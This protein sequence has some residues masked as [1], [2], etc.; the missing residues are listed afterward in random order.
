MPRQTRLPDN[1][2]EQLA[3]E[4]ERDK[5]AAQSPHLAQYTR[6]PLDL[7]MT[8]SIR[9][10]VRHLSY[11][12]ALAAKNDVSIQHLMREGMELLLDKHID[13]HKT[14]PKKKRKRAAKKTG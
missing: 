4:P 9:L 8:Y 6:I 3:E 14:K 13:P 11:I 10:P 7:M 2:K 1:W 12:K 5:C